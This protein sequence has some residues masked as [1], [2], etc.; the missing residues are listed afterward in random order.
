MNLN[1]WDGDLLE[2]MPG[3]GEYLRKRRKEQGL[4]IGDLTDRQIS[5]ATI[6]HIE[7]G[8][9]RVG[10]EKVRYYCSKLG[11]E[12]EELPRYLL[13]ERK[14]KE[15][16]AE[17][18]MLFLQWV[19]FIFYSLGV[20]E[21][22]RM[23][24]KMKWPDG[25]F[26][27]MHNHF[28]RGKCLSAKGKWEK[29]FDQFQHA[30][31]IIKRNPEFLSTNIAASIC[32]EVAQ[33]YFQQNQIHKALEWTDRGLSFFQ[34]NGQRKE[35]LFLLLLS[36]ANY[37]ERLMRT[38]EASAIT[39]SIFT[40]PLR[41]SSDILLRAFALKARICN[42]NQQFEEAIDLTKKGI[43]LAQSEGKVDRCFELMVI[44]AS[45]FKHLGKIRL[46]EIC[47]A[48]AAKFE[49]RIASPRLTALY[50]KEL[51]FLHLMTDQIQ[52]GKEHLNRALHLAEQMNDLVS[53]YEALNALGEWSI[54]QN[55]MEEAVKYFTEA[56]DLM[57][58]HGY[59][60][61]EKEIALKLAKCFEQLGE[62][63]QHQHFLSK[64]YQSSTEFIQH[65]DQSVSQS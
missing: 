21:S 61:Q 59:S 10:I 42:H 40:Y 43:S 30:L 12:I 55:E 8:K 54:Q 35:A 50:H 6:S 2:Q 51:G 4:R 39:E 37:L 23:L 24:R 22:W 65:H 16:T 9:K 41:V 36:K 32:Y 56:Y 18:T 31:N 11:L 27:A 34:E 48:T 47:F 14:Q 44:Q 64:Y 17:E 33:L 63:Q 49:T 45:S 25:D 3:Y 15:Q 19:E 60:R 26:F 5:S 29:A 58:N 1:V 38:E 28:F 13:K 20:Q 46:A 57:E 52:E 53:R 7:T 62:Q